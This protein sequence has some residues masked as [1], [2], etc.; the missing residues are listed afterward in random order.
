MDSAVAALIGATIGAVSGLIGS[1]LNNRYAER[2]H[3]REI[4]FHSGVEVWKQHLALA[5]GD[6][7]SGKIHPPEDFILN[8]LLFSDAAIQGKKIDSGAARHK[9]EE[10]SRISAE[11]WHTRSGIE[12][13]RK[14][15]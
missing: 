12:A 3:R 4:C 8:M 7:G 11:L 15:G 6:K 2:K 1:W 5:T 14:K 9:L 10:S 13:K